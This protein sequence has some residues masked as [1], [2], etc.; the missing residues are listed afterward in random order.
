MTTDFFIAR[1]AL[2]GRKRLAIGNFPRDQQRHQTLRQNTRTL[3]KNIPWRPAA[4]SKQQSCALRSSVLHKP[5]IDSHRPRSRRPLF[6]PK[7]LT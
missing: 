6:A 7:N 4:T 5:G 2:F 3:L 1:G